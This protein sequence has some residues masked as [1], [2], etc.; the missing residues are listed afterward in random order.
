ML[1]GS[2]C[3][4]IAETFEVYFTL[5]MSHC[6]DVSYCASVHLLAVHSVAVQRL[7]LLTWASRDD[8]PSTA[9][10][11]IGTVSHDVQIRLT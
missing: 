3:Q 8:Q 11:H 7:R 5:A 10:T 4:P 1:R 9:Y 6:T 2:S